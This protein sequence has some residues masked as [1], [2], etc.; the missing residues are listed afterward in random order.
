MRHWLCT[1]QMTVGRYAAGSL[2]NRGVY[3]VYERYQPMYVDRSN[4]LADR[5][6]EHGRASGDSET[7][8]FAFNIAKEQFS[9]TTYMSG[10]DLQNDEKFQTLF[11]AAK[12]R[13][14]RLELRVVGVAHPI[15]QTILEVYA[16]VELDTPF[17]SFE[18]H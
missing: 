10:K 15:E 3:A 2:P 14:R 12:K 6:L 18:S 5:L 4:N 1:P 8:T 11:D 17:N 7:A 9:V 13:V 16:Y